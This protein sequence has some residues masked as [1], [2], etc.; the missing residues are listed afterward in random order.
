MRNYLIR[1]MFAAVLLVASAAASFA[2][3]PAFRGKVVDEAGKPVPDAEMVFAAQFQNLTRTNKTDSKGEFLMIGLPSGE[4]VITT[5]KEGVGE[6]I[7]K[8]RITQGQN[9]PVTITLRPAAPTGAL[10]AVV[11][12][13]SPGAAAA[14]ATAELQA[15]AKTGA[16]HLTAGRNDEA[17]AAFNEVVAKAPTCSDCYLNLGMGYTNKKQYAEAETA[18]KKAI[19][20]KADNVSAH[21][22]LALV[23]NAQKKFD[24][25][26]EES[27]LAAKYLGGAD[28]AAAGGGNAEALY[29]QGVALFNGQ[30]FADAKAA[31]QGATKADPTMALAHY[32]LGMVALNLG[33]FALAVSSLETYLKLDPNG[34]KAAEVKTNLPALQKMVKQSIERVSLRPARRSPRAHRRRGP[35][36]RT[37]SSSVRLV[38]VSKTFPIDAVREA[39]AAGHRDFGENRV[40]EALEKISASQDLPD[41]RWHLL[42]HLQSNKARK[43]APAFAMIQA[44]DSIDLLQK[45]DAAAAESGRA[46]ELL[47]QVDLAGEDTKYGTPPTEVPRILD[48]AARCRAARVVGLMTLPPIPDTPEDARPW[49]RRLRDLRDGWLAAGVPAEMLRE[50]SM[51][52][53]GDFE[54][55]I[56]EGATIVRVGTAIFGS[57]Q[58]SALDP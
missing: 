56:Q 14:K 53:S 33:D 39:Y 44:I 1:L 49:F 36:S 52:M 46:P 34:P 32:Q 40:Q 45:L 37:G 42:G 7:S 12:T 43:A 5:K 29:N 3:Q 9:I 13:T 4:F 38:A 30:K 17:I 8:T 57:R 10:A 18:F 55:A 50:M 11:A 54:V 35:G 51:G 41:V 22:Q 48:A 27:A 15:L 23:Y 26:A 25:A 20:L 19:E 2:Q 24:L 47:V 28:G 21:T 6:D 16:A 58:G 31:F